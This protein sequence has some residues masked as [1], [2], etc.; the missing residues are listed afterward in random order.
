ML[1]ISDIARHWMR[2]GH[3]PHIA[4][5]EDTVSVPLSDFRH[6]CNMYMSRIAKIGEM[7]WN[8]GEVMIGLSVSYFVPDMNSKPSATLLPQLSY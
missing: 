1:I 8:S 3:T 4:T 7:M 6:A 5:K 2:R